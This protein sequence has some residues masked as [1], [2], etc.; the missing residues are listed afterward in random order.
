MSILH[1]SSM[2]L[3]TP[4]TERLK[5][6]L[7]TAGCGVVLAYFILHGIM[8]DKGMLALSQMETKLATARADLQKAQQENDRL[9]ART[10]LLRP[11]ALDRDMLDERARSVL[12]YT[13][14]NE[15]VILYEPKR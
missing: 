12:G 11:D 6:W 3:S 2:P 1:S 9:E 7:V 14:P 15:M 10:R 4:V 8:G 13:K 5:H